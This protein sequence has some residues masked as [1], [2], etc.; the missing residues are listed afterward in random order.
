MDML[1]HDAKLLFMNAFSLSGLEYS[2]KGSVSNKA[3][4]SGICVWK[5]LIIDLADQRKMPEFQ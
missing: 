1:G 5:A 4:M 2:D 3:D